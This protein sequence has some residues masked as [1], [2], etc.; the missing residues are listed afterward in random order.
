M[1]IISTIMYSTYI[2][3]VHS[4]DQLTIRADKNILDKYIFNASIW[5]LHEHCL[6][7]HACVNLSWTDLDW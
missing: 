5:E 7:T 1:I 2:Y 4:V 3:C 6:V